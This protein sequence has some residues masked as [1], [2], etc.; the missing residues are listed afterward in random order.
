MEEKLR[1]FLNERFTGKIL[2][3]YTNRGQLSFYVEPAALRDIAVA[4]KDDTELKFDF[5]MDVCSVDHLGRPWEKEG[6]F[7]VVYVLLSLKN[8]YRFMLR[9]KLP[10]D[11]VTIPTL[12]RDWHTAG[13]LV[14]LV[15]CSRRFTG[16][17]FDDDPVYMEAIG[18]Q[19]EPERVDAEWVG[20]A[21]LSARGTDIVRQEIVAMAADGT[22]DKASML[23]LFARLRAAGHEIRVVYITGH[24]LD[25]DDAFD[26]AKA[27]NLM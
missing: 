4:L 6:R 14:D 25:V 16:D 3:E 17:F 27:R 12:S 5:L 20:L 22:L 9:V 26:L 7:E 10:D 23:D 2:S 11:T 21:K 18:N 8:N 1:T 24:W 13:R 15:A 19:L